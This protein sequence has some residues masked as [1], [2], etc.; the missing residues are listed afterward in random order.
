MTNMPHTL[1]SPK[2][3]LA[4]GFML[5]LLWC[6]PNAM[7]QQGTWEEE[8]GEVKSEEIII[9]KDRKIE[10]PPASRRY[11]KVPPLPVAPGNNESV[12][13]DFK[14][15]GFKVAS[16]NPAIRLLKVEKPTLNRLYGNYV[17]LG[18]G[19]FAS[20][21]AALNINNKRN[22]AYAYGLNFRHRASRNG[23]VDGANSGF[24][25][26]RLGLDAKGFTKVGT[27][28]GNISYDRERYHFYGYS[29]EIAAIPERNDISQIFNR[30]SV[31]AGAMKNNPDGPLNF[32][33]KTQFNYM[34]DRFEAREY[35]FTTQ[36]NGQY[37]IGP[38]LT[39]GLESNLY[40]IQQTDST[41]INRNYFNIAPTFKFN[42]SG[43]DITAGFNAVY[44]NDTVPE[45]GQLSL[46]PLLK[47]TYGL[48]EALE[49]YAGIKGGVE[50][51]TWQGLA[52]EN[53]HLG[54]NIPVLHTQNTF[55]FFGGLQ[56]RLLDKMYFHSGFSVGN[57]RY[58]PL[59]VNNQLD[60]TRF[61]VVYDNEISTIF[62]FFGQVTWQQDQNFRASLRGDY[63]NYNMGQLPD[64]WHRPQYVFTI[65]GKYTLKEKLV[66][67][68]SIYLMGGL[69]APRA[70]DRAQVVRLDD[71]TD[72]SLQIEYLFD[73]RFSAYMHLNNILGNN[74]QRFLNYPVRGTM[75][76][77]GL[78][79][80]F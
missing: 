60:S 3:L 12:A 49:V 1:L 48:G 53:P 72:L 11:E 16:L 27:L 20:P 24:S 9:T 40:L 64:A 21:Y 4:C 38:N 33:L 42:V 51:Q 58:L 6:S 74:Y 31:T 47:A 57:Y 22:D 79:Y 63:F 34:N 45:A 36:L 2:A 44:E 70:A 10:L 54:T 25:Q 66:F 35:Y 73:E 32:D 65:D 56:G 61:D 14:N 8:T 78:T 50:V 19:N 17:R 28:Y 75:L 69:E 80:G 30:F 62:N 18:Y 67:G 77:V 68:A 43:F 23:V 15:Y 26:T 46:F 55:N 37:E 59:F 5:C 71:I 29:P 39:A 41:Q 13:F 76:Q 7:A 52:Q